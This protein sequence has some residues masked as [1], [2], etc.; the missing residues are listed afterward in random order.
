M[1]Q[2]RVTRCGGYRAQSLKKV[3]G[4][5]G[6]KSERLWLREMACHVQGDG[7]GGLRD[8]GS[9]PRKTAEGGTCIPH[10]GARGPRYMVYRVYS[11]PPS[12]HLLGATKNMG[13]MGEGKGVV[14]V[15][16][17]GGTHGPD[18]VVFLGRLPTQRSAPCNAPVTRPRN[19]NFYI[20]RYA[21]LVCGRSRRPPGGVR[22]PP[23]GP[24][25]ALG[26]SGAPQAGAKSHT[27]S[28]AF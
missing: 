5:C 19:Q 2:P 13:V 15:L 4:C 14:R 18:L 23:E 28:R 6:L 11:F 10:R 21:A 26:A 7:K 20:R 27:L 1:E 9:W 24:R 16:R 22:R 25:F 8:V 12:P 17:H 3:M